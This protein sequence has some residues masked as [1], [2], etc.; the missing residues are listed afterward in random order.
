MILG[1]GV[2]SHTVSEE[3]EGD[4]KRVKRAL[5]TGWREPKPLYSHFEMAFW[6]SGYLEM[7]FWRSGVLAI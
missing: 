5:A 6:R 2:Y 4:V 1:I 7:A 3:S